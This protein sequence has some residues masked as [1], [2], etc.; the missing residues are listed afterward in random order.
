MDDVYMH[1][2]NG[3]TQISEGDLTTPITIWV[4]ASNNEESTPIKLTAKTKPTYVSLGNTI[5]SFTGTTAS[6]WSMCLTQEGT[7]APTLTISSVIDATT[8]VDFYVK[9]QATSD[10]IP[11]N[12]RSVKINTSGIVASTN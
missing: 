6:K 4:N 12:D 3:A 8:G 10:E 1:I 7:Y 9:A 5:L 2:Y 11:Y